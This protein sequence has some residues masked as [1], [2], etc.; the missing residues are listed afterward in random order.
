MRSNNCTRRAFAPDTLWIRKHDKLFI[1]D[2]SV[3]LSQETNKQIKREKGKLTLS[4]SV[5]VVPHVVTMLI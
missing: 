1:A 4:L 3:V 2:F 5:V